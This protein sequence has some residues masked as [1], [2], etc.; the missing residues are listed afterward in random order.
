MFLD[1]WT[2]TTSQRS[3]QRLHLHDHAWL[4][5]CCLDIERRKELGKRRILQAVANREMPPKGE[6]I[7]LLPEDL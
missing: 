5:P 1:G 2:T 7:T 3:L 6:R 4:R